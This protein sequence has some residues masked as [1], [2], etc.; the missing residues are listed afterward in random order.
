MSVCSRHCHLACADLI[1]DAGGLE[2]VD[3]LLRELK[4]GVRLHRKDRFPA[5]VNCYLFLNMNGSVLA[6]VVIKMQM[7][8]GVTECTL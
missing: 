2:Q 5:S 3:K 8:G 7:T 1:L 4:A 6:F